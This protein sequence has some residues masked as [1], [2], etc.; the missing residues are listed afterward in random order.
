MMNIKEEL[1]KEGAT[2]IAIGSGTQE[3]A[4]YFRDKFNFTGEV[5]LDPELHAYKAF[6]LVRG[7]FKTL[8]PAS[9]WQGVKAI[10]KGFHQG[11][12]AGDLWQQ[13]GIF[14]I[15]P[16][17]QLLFAYR[18]PRAGFHADPNQVV[19]ACHV[20]GSPVEEHPEQGIM[21]LED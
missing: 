20:P 13:G 16:G 18:N 11:L 2:L 14:V 4:V 9:L 8:G 19:A 12:N 5:Y 15:G 21:P 7:F 1:D 3:Q 6:G 10:S 17:N